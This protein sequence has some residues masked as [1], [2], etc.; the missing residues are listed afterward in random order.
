MDSA[1]CPKCEENVVNSLNLVAVNPQNNGTMV[2]L[3]TCGMCHT[4]IGILDT[5][6][7]KTVDRIFLK[8]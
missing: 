8:V 4:I 5:E 3:L 7:A 6:T 2:H 1:L